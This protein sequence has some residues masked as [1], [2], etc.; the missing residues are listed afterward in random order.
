MNEDFFACSCACDINSSFVWWQKIAHVSRLCRKQSSKSC[1]TEVLLYLNAA[2]L[3]AQHRRSELLHL[4]FLSFGRRLQV[5]ELSFDAIGR[6]S[7]VNLLFIAF[8]SNMMHSN[9]NSALLKSASYILSPLHSAA[10]CFPRLPLLLHRKPLPHASPPPHS[11]PHTYPLTP[12]A[13]HTYIPPRLPS[14]SSEC[15]SLPG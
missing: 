1:R 5:F 13:Y 8:V 4:L 12:P 14:A 9:F 11:I 2:C 15:V 10:L 7:I 6:T 3:R